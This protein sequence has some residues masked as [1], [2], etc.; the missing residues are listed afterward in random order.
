MLS[1]ALPALRAIACFVALLTLARAQTFLAVEHKGKA[2]VVREVRNG[3]PYVADG[4][5]LVAVRTS[6]AGLVPAPEFLPVFVSVR[7]LEVSTAYLN[8]N[9]SDMNHE[10]RLAGKLVS[11]YGL[12]KVFLVLELNTERGGK[13]LHFQEV[14]KLAPNQPEYIR[15]TVPMSS[16][17]GDGKYQLHVFAAGPEV[18]HSE[19]PWQ[20]REGMLDRMVRK[21]IEGVTAAGPKPFVG[22]SPVYPPKHLKARLKGE[23]MVKIRI[24]PTGVVVD[25]ELQTASDPAF[26]EAAMDVIRQWRFLPRVLDGK[27]V[28]TIAAMP[29]AFEPPAA[30]DEK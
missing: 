28:S 10:F 9:G 22:P 5:K 29:F 21:R 30:A 19:Q 18:F 15:A 4:E 23:A 16:P 24:L 8:V 17:L 13:R 3:L 7:E 6:K 20:F 2:Q 1:L 12:E 14:G 25:P 11:P 27:P 26:G